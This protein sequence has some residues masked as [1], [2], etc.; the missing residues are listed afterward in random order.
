M[1][2]APKAIV[3]LGAAQAGWWAARTLR[4][5]GFDGRLTL[6]GIEQHPPYERPPLS[7]QVLK[8][9]AEPPSA[10]LATPAQLADLKIEFLGGR[11]AAAIDRA[12][13]VVQLDDGGRLGY[14]RLIIATGARPRRLDL[15][16]ER[17]APVF[18]LRDIADCLAI[19]ERLQPGRQV[20]IVGGGLIGLEAAAAARARGCAVTVIEAAGRLMA[21]VVGPEISAFMRRMHERQGVTV[22]TERLPVR[23]EPSGAGCRVIC[24]DG[25][26]CE[27]DAV[28]VGVGIVPD[29]EIAAEAGLKVDN[30]LWVDEFCRS[31]DPH[32]WA[33][34]D[35]T[36]H[37]NPLLGRRLRL[38]TWQNAQN[39]GIAA[40]RNCLGPPQPY[41]EVPWGWSDQYAVN[42]Q[43]LGAPL[44]FADTIVRGDPESESFTV[45]Y[46]EGD[47]LAGVNAVN[48]PKDIAVAR[49][50][51][52]ANKAV[53]RARLRDAATPLRTL[54][55]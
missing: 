53:D 47:R 40:A 43:L 11:R 14:G 36:C 46:L 29:V 42:L 31:E 13:R 27:A 21:R 18:Y 38:E 8:G 1:S 3:V 34:G 33:A 4:A 17:D 22:L 30:G 39:Q 52:A 16:G 55:G 23:F 35:V 49:R 50:L 5:Q 45:F 10:W 26:A 6:I 32:I 2:D 15:P 12:G 28:V 20:A 41:A 7:K 37:L 19:R 48:A 24:G 44:S 25:T 9:E 54:L 51:M